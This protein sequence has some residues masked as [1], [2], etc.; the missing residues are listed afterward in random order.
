MKIEIGEYSHEEFIKYI[1]E[2][3]DEL[4]KEGPRKRWLKI[5]CVLS[6]DGSWK[7]NL[8]KPGELSKIGAVFKAIT[9]GD[10]GNNEQ[11]YYVEEYC[12]GMILIYNTATNDEYEEYLGNRIDRSRGTT[13]MW[14]KPSIFNDFWRGILD[15]TGGFVCRFM[16]KRGMI[17]DV[18]SKLRPDYTRR[19]NYTGA[20]G[21]QTLSELEDVY[22]VTPESIYIQIS[23]NLEIHVTNDGLY[24][25]QEISPLALDV[26]FKHLDKIKE[27]I[28]KIMAVSTSLKFVITSEANMKSVLVEPGII[29]LRNAE[30]SPISSQRMIQ[31]MDKFSFIDVYKAFGSF[32]IIAT[33]VDEMK[34]SIFNIE[35]SESQIV[36]I[37]KFRVTFESFINFYRNIV[38]S[39]DEYAEFTL[40]N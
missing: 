2:H 19:F 1:I 24:S 9:Q 15:E 22:G 10:G 4:L 30:I 26:F 18:P 14:M 3:S 33:V 34:G 29:T 8:F 23:A 39:I 7:D 35:A 21:T 25:T 6:S 38:E 36:I 17:D 16:S 31:A 27:R 37:P 5:Y 28:L 20:D 11:Q 40:L 32:S 13:R 12:P